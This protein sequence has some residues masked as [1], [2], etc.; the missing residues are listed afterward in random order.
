ME[1]K[2]HLRRFF[3][4]DRDEAERRYAMY[5]QLAYEDTISRIKLPKRYQLEGIGFAALK[6]FDKVWRS[7]K[8]LVKWDW[9]DQAQRWKRTDH[10]RLEL[11]VWQD[12][13]LCG[14]MIGRTSKRKTIVYVLGIEGAPYSHPLKG[15]IIPLA[16]EVAEAYAVAVG[17]KELRLDKPAAILV[18]RYEKLGYTFRS[19]F[20]GSYMA[21]K[22]GE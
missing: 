15:Y 10:S 21:K 14:L 18:A 8:R 16:L 20:F 4:L 17:A 1:I 13:E 11:A 22:M 19:T 7:H 3:N 2:V 6:S 9:L 5:R 12:G